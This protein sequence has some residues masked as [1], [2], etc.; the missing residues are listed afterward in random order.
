MN[1]VGWAKAMVFIRAYALP[2]QGKPIIRKQTKNSYDEQSNSDRSS[3]KNRNYEFRIIQDL[4]I[5]TLDHLV[6]IQLLFL[7]LFKI[8]EE[9]FYCPNACR[10]Q[11]Q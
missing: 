7:G 6:M 4:K 1:E 2:E 10:I 3:E 5:S 9:D 8:N 11:R